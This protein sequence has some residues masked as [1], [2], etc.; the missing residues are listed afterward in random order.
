MNSVPPRPDHGLAC[1]VMCGIKGDVEGAGGDRGGQ[2]K[3]SDRDSKPRMASSAVAREVFEPYCLTLSG[4]LE[5]MELSRV[6]RKAPTSVR[7]RST[8][9]SL[10]VMRAYWRLNTYKVGKQCTKFIL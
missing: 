1:I 3:A 10:N 2:C 4:P 6:S 7:E 9:P 5:S 8:Q